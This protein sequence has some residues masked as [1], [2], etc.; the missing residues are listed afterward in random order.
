LFFFEET[1]VQFISQLGK[2][3]RKNDFNIYFYLLKNNGLC[4]MLKIKTEKLFAK[5]EKSCTFANSNLRMT[6]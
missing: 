2:L 6:K 3:F 4:K 1:K 5:R